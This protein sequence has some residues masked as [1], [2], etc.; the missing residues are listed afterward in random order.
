MLIF[1][2]KGRKSLKF[3]E[4][5][6]GDTVIGDLEQCFLLLLPEARGRVSPLP[7]SALI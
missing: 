4:G 2:T 1:L 7:S 6:S 5:V 3:G